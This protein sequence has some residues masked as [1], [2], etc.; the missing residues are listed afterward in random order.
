MLDRLVRVVL[1]K[2]LVIMVVMRLFFPVQ[3]HM[4]E[5]FRG[6][7]FRVIEQRH[8]T[9]HGG[10]AEHREQHKEGEGFTHEFQCSRWFCRRCNVESGRFKRGPDRFLRHF[11]IAML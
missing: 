9:G 4:G 1:V 5:R 6:E 10:L 7:R 2:R 8:P 11:P 3:R